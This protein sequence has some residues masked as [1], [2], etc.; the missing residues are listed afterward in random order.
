MNG[1]IRQG[2]GA[3]FETTEVKLRSTGSQLPPE[4]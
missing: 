2:F 1:C 3:Q 4:G